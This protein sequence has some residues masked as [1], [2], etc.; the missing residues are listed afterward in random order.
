MRTPIRVALKREMGEVTK[1]QKCC[2][3][4]AVGFPGPPQGGFYI[5]ARAL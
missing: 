3:P 4:R 2:L 5:V 1:E